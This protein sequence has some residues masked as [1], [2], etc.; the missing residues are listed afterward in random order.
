MGEFEINFDPARKG[1]DKT[2]WVVTSG[3]YSSYGIEAVFSS[4]EKAHQFMKMKV[5][6]EKADNIQVVEWE[7]DNE[8]QG[9]YPET[10]YTTTYRVLM[11]IRT[12][13]IL[14]QEKRHRPF[15][16]KSKSIIELMESKWACLI[17]GSQQYEKECA[18]KECLSQNR[19]YID[20]FIDCESSISFEHATKIAAEYRQKVLRY[21]NE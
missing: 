16:C 11:R 20:T 9:E 2:V 17:D 18:H 8:K 19:D 4:E 1:E 7:I 13:D 6:R 12:G 14:S 21:L 10:K 5:E 3:E 15:P